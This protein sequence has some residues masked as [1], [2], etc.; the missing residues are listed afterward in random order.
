[1]VLAAVQNGVTG[2]D[3]FGPLANV[4]LTV[5]KA[6]WALAAPSPNRVRLKPHPRISPCGYRKQDADLLDVATT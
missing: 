3:T 2:V 4:D 5:C 1:M 6:W